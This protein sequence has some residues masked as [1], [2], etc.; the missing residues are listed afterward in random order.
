[1]KWFKKTFG[2]AAGAE[3]RKEYAIRF[4]GEQDGQIEKEIKARWQPI[5]ATFSDVRRAYLAIASFDQSQN[6]QVVLCIQSKK[7]DD[8][9]LVMLLL[10]HS[11]RC[12][13]PLRPST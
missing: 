7:G 3:T 9:L 5:L 6:Y 4:L 13:M 11:V 12:S 1:M 8:P 2:K 10:S